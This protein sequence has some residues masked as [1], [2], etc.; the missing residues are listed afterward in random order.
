MDSAAVDTA[1]AGLDP[2]DRHRGDPLKRPSQLGRR[3]L[4]RKEDVGPHAGQLVRRLRAAELADPARVAQLD[5][6][7]RAVMPGGLD[8]GAEIS[9]PG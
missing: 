7:E 1:A 9:L 8:R 5:G 6:K 3:R 2:D 4:R